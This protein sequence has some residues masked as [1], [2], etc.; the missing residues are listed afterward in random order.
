MWPNWL[1]S[2]DSVPERGGSSTAA[3]MTRSSRAD[4]YA[5]VDAT[6]HGRTKDPPG[7]N[8]FCPCF[9]HIMNVSDRLNLRF[10]C[11]RRPWCSGIHSVH[12]AG[13]LDVQN[14]LSA[15]TGISR[16]SEGHSFGDHLIS[17][18]VSVTQS[19]VLDAST[20]LCSVSL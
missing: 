10:S 20:V 5:G 8:R 4:W 9:A 2:H 1:Y 7:H 14:I 12:S 19:S 15:D 13:L 17:G 16:Q 11:S 6:E 18:S 3:G